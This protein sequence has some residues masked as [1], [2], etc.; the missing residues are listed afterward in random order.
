MLRTL[1]GGD[2][3]VRLRGR[4]QSVSTDLF[5]EL[6]ENPTLR[7]RHKRYSSATQSSTERPHSCLGPFCPRT[8]RYALGASET[9]THL[10]LPCETS[11][12]QRRLTPPCAR[13]KR[14]RFWNIS[15]EPLNHL[16][17]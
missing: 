4:L 13:I 2:S 10:R 15:Q 16:D 3:R 8:V 6:I 9:R 17:R 7:A 12:C 11:K 14:F 5:R 1:S